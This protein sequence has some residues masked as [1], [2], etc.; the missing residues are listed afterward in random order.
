MSAKAD[1]FYDRA[2]LKNMKI[3]S[4]HYLRGLLAIGVMIYHFCSGILQYKYYYNADSIL[5]RV[6]NYGVSLFFILSGLTLYHVYSSEN[7][8]SKKKLKKYFVKRFFRI[9]PLFILTTIFCVV[10]AR[11]V[12]DLKTIALNLSGLFAFTNSFIPIHKVAWSVGNEL[13]FYSAFPILLLC[14]Q[15]R[16]WILKLVPLILFLFL[17]YYG[18]TNI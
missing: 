2:F 1:I 5:V 13:V 12:Y 14:L 8:F 3:N 6:G 10:F 7:F 9:Y 11:Q 17:F 15:Q 16:Y 18:V 4:L